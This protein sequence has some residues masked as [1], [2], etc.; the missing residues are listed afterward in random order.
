MRRTQRLIFLASLVLTFF[1]VAAAAQLKTGTVLQAI[2]SP[3]GLLDVLLSSDT[4]ATIRSTPQHSEDFD[5]RADHHRALETLPRASTPLAA[6]AEIANA[7]AEFQQLHPRAVLRWSSLTKT[8]SRIVAQAEALTTSSNDD[9]EMI[10]R[11]FLQRELFQLDSA[12][13]NAL[14]MAQRDHT[15]HNGVTHITLQ[16]QLNGIEIFGARM[17]VHLNRA[18]EVFAA[19]GELI[20][21]LTRVAKSGQSGLPATTALELAAASVGLKLEALPATLEAAGT[22]REQTLPRTSEL[23]REANA[24]LVYFPLAADKLAL[25][26]EVEVWPANAPDAYLTIID[27]ARG[28]L[29]YRRNLT[30]YEAA[31]HGLV[32]AGESP[33]PNNPTTTTMP[34]VVERQD[35]PFRPAPFNGKTIFAANDRHLDWWAGK[36]P[37][38]LIGNNVAAHLD[39]NNDDKPDVPTVQAS[40]SDFAFPLDLAKA[41]TTE[42]NQ[43]AAQ[44]NLF[45]WTNRFH[46]I[47]YSF[48][49]TETAGNFQ[50]DNFNLGGQSNDAIQ[51]DAQD[52]SGFNNANFTTPPDGRAGRMQMF[53]WNG[54]P[55]LDGSL[56]QTV[57]LHELAHG[58]SNRLI[59]N[60]LGLGGLHA[61]GLG[62][63]WS[64]YLALALLAK[65]SDPIDG[66][67]LIAQY[68][69]N[70]YSRGLRFTPYSTDLNV[71]PR[72]L[73]YIFFN[74]LPHP[75]GEIW[76]ATLWDLRALLIKQY[77]FQEGQHQSIQLVLDAMK[78]TP[79]E[80]SF[81]EARDAI[82]LADRVNNNGRNQCLLWQAFA[83][84]GLGFSALARDVYDRRPAESFDAPPFCSSL[85]TLK[86]DKPNYVNGESVF[87]TL[88]DRNA[89]APVTVQ[90]T[91]SATGDQ[92]TITLVPSAV[93]A[94]S[95]HSTIKTQAARKQANDGLLQAS[96]D[97]GD[98]LIVSYNDADSTAPST[99]QAS[100]VR[101][102]TIFDDNVERGNQGWIATGSWAITNAALAST[103]TGRVWT[104]SPAGNYPNLSDSSLTSPLFDL[105]NYSDVTLVFAER[106][107]L[108]NRYDYGYVEYS[109]DDGATWEYATSFTG[110]QM[111]FASAQIKLDA[112]SGQ[113]KTRFRF[114]VLTDLEINADGWFIDDIRLVG[115]SGDARII[116]PGN[117]PAPNVYAV[118]PTF[119][120]IAGGTRVTISGANF[121]DTA[122]TSV[123]F[124]GVAASNVQVVS[125]NTI[126]ATTPPHAA[127][128]VAVRIANRNGGSSL[129]FGFT[130]WAGEAGTMA[131]TIN[132][133]VPATGSI[134]GGTVVTIDGANFTPAT[135]VR[136][137]AQPVTPTFI[138]PRELRV[139]T[140]TATAGAV[141]V[142]LANDT[143]TTTRNAAF[144]YLNTT[145]PT[146]QLSTLHDTLFVGSAVALRW[147]S[148]DDRAVIKH[149]L[150]L[151]HSDGSVANE[152]APALNGD[153]QSLVW[154][155][156]PV[157]ASGLRV[158]IVATD[159]D[160]NE[161]SAESA[162]FQITRRWQTQAP[163]PNS[164]WQFPVVT[165][166]RALFAM[167]GLSGGSGTTVNTLSRFD[168]GTNSWTTLAPMKR[169]I[170]SHDAVFL[171]GKIY[172]PGG[173]L[174]S[175]LVI[176]NHQVY[177]IATNHW[178]EVLEPPVSS[179]FYALVADAN[180]NAY[181]RITGSR[182]GLSNPIPDVLRYDIKANEWTPLSDFPEPRYG[183]EAT[184]ID[185]KIYVT[186]GAD[187]NGGKRSSWTYDPA[188]D[189][190]T[191]IASLNRARRFAAS[192]VGADLAGNPWWFIFGGDDPNTGLPLSD[193]E[194]YDVRNDRWLLL[195]DSFALRVGR[196]NTASTGLN[197]KLYALGGAVL[198]DDGKAYVI[199]NTVEALPINPITPVAPDQPP[200]LAAP[201]EIVALIGDVMT[202]QIAANDLGSG[203]ALTLNAQ[204][205]P[206]AAEF[207]V[208]PETNNSTRG[209]IRWTPTAADA[210]QTWR[211]TF[212][213]SDGQLV[214]ARTTVLR[215][216]AADSMAV[217]NAASYYGGAVAADSI[218]TVFGANLALRSESAQ[219][220]PLPLTMAGASVTVNGLPAQ[221]L[222]VS[223]HQ[224]NFVIPPEV[225][226]GIAS[227][228]VRNS[229]G[230]FA[231]GHITIA[232]AA[233]AIFTADAS[234][235]G[236]AA[237]VATADGFTYQQSPFA[238][239]VNGQP[240]YLLLFGT[241]LRRASNANNE[242]ANGIAERVAVTI[243]GIAAKVLYAG[244]QGQ[245]VGL[246]Q[247]NIEL[248][249]SLAERL[250]NV[251][252]RVEVVV[253]VN[254]VEANRTSVWLRK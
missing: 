238:V 114:R 130:Y 17:S 177:D 201:S 85:G 108:E 207:L 196:T 236:D 117:A 8:P 180:N 65:E 113:A 103:L 246:D 228:V 104:D 136:F 69:T 53:L 215:V 206:A 123:T 41:P 214:D 232:D 99:G 190:W 30:C 57:I 88:S 145:P 148:T 220:I 254:G 161:S 253:S 175:G 21:N 92:E 137:G 209:T 39:R 26:W 164:L 84:R 47:L 133:L 5:I 226:P 36:M 55:Q 72:T 118:T 63:G 122:D 243:G 186:G 211:V 179:Q 248:P 73:G 216:V 167:G 34:P 66:Q 120:G 199:S 95:F 183:H 127:G 64:D 178:T 111:S 33:R 87:I 86:L 202:F 172:V 230:G 23:A 19:N 166:G 157:V 54:S 129:N 242:D 14:R 141:N 132:R 150:I 191:P 244:A 192:A 234:G 147:S 16:Q 205:L 222:Y 75:V 6:R 171:N 49:F 126:T 98:Q 106:R 67:Y 151:L 105:T 79:I 89:K 143:F 58:V 28:S 119:G 149:R 109:L 94:G 2:A 7:V 231:L 100:M 159:D 208:Q 142:T 176:T 237:A 156:P 97:A 182:L 181:Y 252:S 20:P 48:G 213:A 193:G 187:R 140:P 40:N 170:S 235:R 25:A 125:H 15:A 102:K 76:C 185:D 45:Y 10:A 155:I 245:Y 13:A 3:S 4:S 56:D 229:F 70:Q 35:L 74:P 1:L 50:T 233:P 188:T 107:D 91:S 200:V 247:L 116:T 165:D 221:L 227:V 78:L 138:N 110:T 224:I 158:R 162:P 203:V 204:G 197:G 38:D 83:K 134:N 46:D 32:W 124:N 225:E 59:G 146:V 240:N 212:T 128:T 241:G 210:G 154:T 82:L 251:P 62:E 194:V 198:S 12:D 27:A 31:P 11:R 184:M 223:D 77:G 115:R 168:P 43:K 160:G 37:T 189:V 90:I 217:V 249:A 152:I 144:N 24:R 218:A 239:T 173:A 153:Q 250:S 174:S 42:D 29:L 80:P 101:E 71:S 131:P 96:V 169:A 44:A 52:G 22:A 51:A 93:Q 60:G 61:R 135:K 68:A 18:G 121:T 163:L 9:A 139:V 81:T 112:L 219:A 195:D